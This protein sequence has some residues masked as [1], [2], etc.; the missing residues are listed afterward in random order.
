MSDQEASFTGWC[1]L[2]LMGHRRLAGWLSEETIGGGSFIRID[3]PNDDGE[4]VQ[5]TQFYSP[6]SVYCITPTTEE[7]AR[8]AARG[9]KP[10]PVARWELGAPRHDDGDDDIEEDDEVGASW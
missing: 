10:A 7:I 9:A 8:A 5:A 3:V 2:E 1:I 6:S 4:T